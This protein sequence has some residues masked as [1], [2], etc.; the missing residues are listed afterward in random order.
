MSQAP[1]EV[2]GFGPVD[3]ATATEL[4][5]LATRDPSTRWCVTLTG[6]DGQAVGHG[7]AT[8]N[9]ARAPSAGPPGELGL[10]KSSGKA[11][12]R[13]GS[14]ET[15]AR[16]GGKP[17]T[18]HL[19]LSIE[20][21]AT[22]SCAHSRE[23]P[24][25]SPRLSLRHLIEIRDVCCAFPTCR[26]PAV[27]CDL[28]HTTPYQRGGRSCECNLAPLCRLHHEIKQAEGWQLTQPQPGVFRWRTPSGRTYQ[29]KPGSLATPALYTG[30]ARTAAAARAGWSGR[31]W[32]PPTAT[33]C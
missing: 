19:A 2:G 24:G 8:S 5:V 28:D 9:R 11:G 25:Y 31:R 17:G 6:P 23:V 10:G 26:R 22:G 20:P 32:R 16:A 3:A 15:A 7:C 4:A 18:W 14:A 27:Q 1:G 33:H 13:G 29:T 21:L 12:R 30:A